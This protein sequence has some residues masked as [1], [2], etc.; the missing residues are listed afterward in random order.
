MSEGSCKSGLFDGFPIAECVVDVECFLSLNLWLQTAQ[1]CN[2]FE[3]VDPPITK[4]YKELLL[5]LKSVVEKLK[6]DRGQPV[7]DEGREQHFQEVEQVNH[8]LQRQ[9][10][11]MD[12][13][14]GVKDTEMVKKDELLL[15]KDE[16]LLEKD[17]EL[18]KM[19]EQL[20]KKDEELQKKVQ[21]LQAKQKELEEL[22]LK[23]QGRTKGCSTFCGFICVFVVGI[24]FAMLFNGIAN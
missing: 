7:V 12:A 3:W 2:F 14:M 1:D 18:L 17:E 13:Q 24:V 10:V 4:W 19:E 23:M 9:L 22:K 8:S 6:K 15:K 5:D 16:E 11:I 20:V 21:E